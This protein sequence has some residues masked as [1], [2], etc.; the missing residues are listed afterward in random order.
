M[1]ALLLGA[2]G[3]S[4][5]A[6]SASGLDVSVHATMLMSGF[7]NS[8]RF[9]NADV[10]TVAL[11]GTTGSAF[12]G[13]VRQTR[14]GLTA[15]HESV[16]GGRL[17]AELDADFFGGQQP[18]GG[19]RTHPLLRIRR[20]YA[21]IRWPTATLLVGQESPA[22]FGVSPRSIAASGFP[23]LASAG[24]LWLWLPQIRLTK[25]FSEDPAR[26]RVGLEG[27]LVA[28][29]GG[30]PVDPF[31]TQPD[32]AEQSGRPNLEG[33]ILAR[34]RQGGRD[35]EIGVGGHLGWVGPE[36]TR[37]TS[38]AVGA[39]VVAP[40]GSV[41]EVRGEVF[42]GQALAGLGGGGIG[43]NLLGGEPVETKGG[44]VQAVLLPTKEVEV[45]LSAGVDDPDDGAL[46]TTARF[47][48]RAVA[49]NLTWRRAP[50]VAGFEFRRITTDYR[51]PAA[52]GVTARG[53]HLHLGL[54]IEF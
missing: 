3:S 36:A 23:Q 48:N 54:G 37:V 10:P 1:L 8:G 47:R 26:F 35:G 41:F 52:A 16:L 14:V 15:A 25:W 2:T 28:P 11:V 33:R 24:N 6:Q 40:M 51:T 31:L 46:P 43:Q 20:A 22:L 5:P 53:S 32:L 13:T 9:N 19:G 4:L 29:N 21:E 45:G 50:V 30:E 18:S 39:S 34:W 42:S 12:G 17:F 7:R 38:R 49:A 27:A 44:W